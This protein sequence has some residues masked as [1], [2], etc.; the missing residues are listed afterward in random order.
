MET[1]CQT[2]KQHFTRA[3]SEADFSRE[4]LYFQFRKAALS[5][6]GLIPNMAI[7]RDIIVPKLQELLPQGHITKMNA[8]AL[9]CANAIN[10]KHSH[11][12]TVSFLNNFLKLYNAK[13]I[14]DV[15][16]IEK[17]KVHSSTWYRLRDYYLQSEG[18]EKRLEAAKIWCWARDL[19]DATRGTRAG[20]LWGHHKSI[21]IDDVQ[22]LVAQYKKPE[23]EEDNKLVEEGG[24]Q[25]LSAFPKNEF[26]PILRQQM[27]KGHLSETQ[28][29]IILCLI[30]HSRELRRDKSSYVTHPMAV[31]NLV[32]KY[33]AQSLNDPEDVWMATL[34]ALLHDGGEKSNINLDEDLNGLLPVQVIEGIKAI[35]KRDHEDYFQYLERC[36]DNPL[37]AVVKLCDIYHNSLDDLKPSSKQEYVYPIS[38]LYMEY[39]TK[40]PDHKISVRDFVIQQGIASPDQFEII[41]RFAGVD[42]KKSVEEAR[43]EIGLIRISRTIRD[44]FSQEKEEDRRNAYPCR[45]EAPS[46]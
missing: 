26:L 17:I 24:K 12:D 37:S 5:V 3:A 16:K 34:V 13:T 22:S 2:L 25:T 4:R 28:C 36:A 35:H 7:D 46:L 44:I 27:D 19:E 10:H 32:R 18:K 15:C 1:F 40:N 31:A 39:R 20:R 30:L 45:E 43:K 6:L 42:R 21:L 23:K 9:L 11:Y 14:D 8:A 41:S 33:G 38:A 29:G